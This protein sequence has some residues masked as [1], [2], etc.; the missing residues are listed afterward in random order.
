MGFLGGLGGLFNPKPKVSL[1]ELEY[2]QYIAKDAVAVAEMAK[3]EDGKSLVGEL[4]K[5]MARKILDGAL[6]ATGVRVPHQVKD[7]AIEASV[8]LL[9]GKKK[10]R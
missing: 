6:E 9:F 2:T 3:G 7:L 4:K 1:E 5:A 8:S 10:K